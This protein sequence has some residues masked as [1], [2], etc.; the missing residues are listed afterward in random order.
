MSYLNAIVPSCNAVVLASAG[1]GKTWLLVTRIIR[2]LLEGTPPAGILAI[3]FTRKAALEMQERLL[4][5]LLELATLEDAELDAALTTL[6]LA[7]DTTQRQQVRSAYETLLKSEHSPRI[8]TFHAF[9]QELLRRFPLE[10]DVPPGFDLIENAGVLAQAALEA[11]LSEA[12][13]LPDSP[14]AQALEHLMQ[15]ARGAEGVR[16]LLL[17]FLEHRNDWWACT[18]GAADP[19]VHATQSLA[20]QLHVDSTGTLAKSFF[21][22]DT[23]CLLAEFATLLLQHPIAS[24]TRDAS[25][26]QDVL[27]RQEKTATD[28]SVVRHVFLTAEDAPRRR[29]PS[30]T[31]SDKLGAA[32]AARLITLHEQLSDL[33]LQALEQEARRT[34]LALSTAWFESGARLLQHYQRI[35]TEQRL[36]DFSDLEW[37]A[38]QLLQHSDNA[39]WVQYKLDQRIDHL[40]VDEFQDTNP[41]QWRLLLPLLEELAAG[42]SGR[43]RSVFLVGDLKQSI[44]GF[45]RAN[46][47]LFTTAAHWLE[48]HLNTLSYPLDVSWRFAPVL[49]DFFNQVFEQRLPGFHAHST[50]RTTLWGQVELLPLIQPEQAESQPAATTPLRNPLRQPRPALSEQR[51]LLEGQQIARRIRALIETRTAIADAASTRALS[52][53]DI[54]IL[55]RNRTH[56]SAYESALRDAGIPFIGATRGSLLETLEVQDMIAL[57]DVLITPYDNLALAQVLRSPLFAC[58]DDDLSRLATD[59]TAP[60]WIDRLATLAAGLAE[61][62]PLARAHRWLT[63]WR[64]RAAQ[65]PMHDLLD[66][67]Y[68]EGNVLARYEAAFPPSLKTRVCANLIRF[69]ELALEVDSGR[70]P[71]PGMF[72]ARLNALRDGA[73]QEAPDEAPAPAHE[74]RVRILTVHAAKGLEAPVVFVADATALVSSR[75]A[76]PL[77]Y[78]PAET[79]RPSHFFLPAKGNIAAQLG[80]KIQQLMDAAAQREEMNLLYVALTRAR[81]YLF[82]S[83][84]APMKGTALGWYGMIAERLLPD[85]D[86]LQAAWL[87]HSIITPPPL[88]AMAPPAQARARADI[89]PRLSQALPAPRRAKLTPSHTATDTAQEIHDAAAALRGAAIH[90][91]L[92]RLSLDNTPTRAHALRQLADE[93]LL[94]ANDARLSEWWDEARRVLQTPALQFL[95][96]D[97]LIEAVHNETPLHYET[98]G[99][100]VSG[101][102]DR[103]VVTADTVWIVDYKTRTA[104]PASL[105]QAA[106]PYHEQMRCYAQ[107]A[108]RIWPQRQIRAVLLFT[109]CT[110]L[111]EIPLS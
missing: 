52:Y 66:S 68:A 10:A 69:M 27:T 98:D 2:L 74:A 70:Y 51:H 92:D 1:T 64:E 14:L 19:A 108:L 33:A 96:A 103:L 104:Q 8:T 32:G 46:P 12:T 54:L 9:C 79:D 106:A 105:A 4:Q 25:L 62:A 93:L 76:Q 18:A 45:R 21:T 17:R 40:L 49:C 58:S 22:V 47:E 29:K 11:L 60:H 15:H 94:D 75:G 63:Q 36:L 81:Q 67:I 91:L 95:F 13:K 41:T 24:N 72:R 97:D 86:P 100:R 37:K 102:V 50:H 57:L 61:D 20:E 88:P 48:Q 90:R 109:A 83:G 3:T 42:Q 84:C 23:C 99:Q 78:W 85:G 110:T 55:V 80:A 44:Y 71:S 107:G 34:T 77:I 73:A 59:A 39:L 65:V 82:I 89:D 87:Q 26:I 28:F 6:G 53:N 35:K 5:R 56:V 16:T 30:K 7:A 38:S 31:L 111:V 43:A 101:V